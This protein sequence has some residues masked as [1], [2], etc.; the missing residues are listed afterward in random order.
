MSK[1]SKSP[2]ISIPEF[3]K[4]TPPSFDLYG[5]KAE[6]GNN[7]YSISEN[8]QQLL[9]RQAAEQVRRDLISSLGLQGN[10]A[11]DPFAKLYM[12]ESL[13]IA[14]P[15]LENALIQRGLGGSTVYQ[16]AIT[17]LINKASTDAQLNA[18]QRTLANL[19]GVGGNYLEPLY[20]RGMQLL[21]ASANTGLQEEQLAQQRY[22][23]TLPYMSTVNTPGNSG[24][25]GAISGGLN[26]LL[27]SGGNPFAALGGAGA[28]YLT[29][30]SPSQ[31]QSLYEY[32]AAQ[33]AA[34]QS[35]QQ[36]Q[37][38]ALLSGGGS[39]KSFMSAFGS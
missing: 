20:A 29:S 7:T 39:G 38:L 21:G 33:Q 13:R 5:Q 12:Q 28:G 37:L 24:I 19:A 30:R 35:N 22:L 11:S 3:K 18:N 25:G 31:S 6:F 9:D 34:Q 15:Q 36:N 1:S 10:P 16:N 23:A 32:M 4:P 17:D 8:P 2:S 27:M 26:A 14:Q